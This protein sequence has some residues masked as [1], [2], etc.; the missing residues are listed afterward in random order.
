LWREDAWEEV[1][2]CMFVLKH[3]VVELVCDGVGAVLFEAATCAVG[4]EHGEEVVGKVSAWRGGRA[5][6]LGDLWEEMVVAVQDEGVG[7]GGE[8]EKV[9][10]GGVE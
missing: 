4:R 2:V 7:I 10:D 3:L 9:S 6:S 5:C 8:G 1:E